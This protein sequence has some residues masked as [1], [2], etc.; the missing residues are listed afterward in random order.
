[1]SNVTLIGIIAVAIVAFLLIRW[2][3]Y[4]IKVMREE[5]EERREKEDFKKSSDPFGRDYFKTSDTNRSSVGYKG[6][7]PKSNTQYEPPRQQEPPKQQESPKQ[8]EQ[9]RQKH[10]AEGHKPESAKGGDDISVTIINNRTD[11]APARKIFED[12]EGE[13]VEFTEE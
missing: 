11:E 5:M 10:H 3:I 9:P 12:H 13:Y 2:L 8:Q 7:V 6:K 4:K 1:M